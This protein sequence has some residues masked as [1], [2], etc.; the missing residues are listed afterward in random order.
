MARINTLR[1]EI[2]CQLCKQLTQ[3]PDMETAMKVWELF[4]MCASCFS[5]SSYMVKFLGSFLLSRV[6]KV[7]NQGKNQSSLTF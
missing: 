7:S 2:Y 1:N 4:A 5:C 6:S 3:N